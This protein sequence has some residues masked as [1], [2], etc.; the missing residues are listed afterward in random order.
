[1]RGEFMNSTV[2]P[3][4]SMIPVITEDIRNWFAENCPTGPAVLGISGGKDS[5]VVA[6]LLAD[7]LGPKRVIGVLMPNGIQSDIDD[8]YKV[9]K[10]LGIQH[11]EVNIQNAISGLYSELEKSL[12]TPP[13]SPQAETNVPPRIRMTTLYAIAQ[14]L[15]GVVVG[16][17]NA[18]EIYLGWFTKWGDGANDYNFLKD[19]T[20]TEVIALGDALGLPRSLVHKTPADGLCGKSDEEKFG[21]T[22]QVLD[23]YIRGKAVPP[24]DIK[25]KIDQMHNSTAHKR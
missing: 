7:A 25:V 14:T 22:Y 6:T 8:S 21:F 13:I 10:L 16:T 20:A 1:M 12:G 9:I 3:I 4:E 19:Y 18:S 17:G 23:D 11:Y 24:D 2:L 15:G 5:T